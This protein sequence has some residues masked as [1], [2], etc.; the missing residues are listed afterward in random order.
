MTSKQEVEGREGAKE[1]QKT[2]IAGP[3]VSVENYTS[4]FHQ[5]LPFILSFLA[6]FRWQHFFLNHP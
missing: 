1:K 5:I 4:D 3:E 2:S 6:A